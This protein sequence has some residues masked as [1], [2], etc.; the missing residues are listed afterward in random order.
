MQKKNAYSA[1][2]ARWFQD[3]EAERRRRRLRP[4]RKVHDFREPP[5]NPDDIRA[6]LDQIGHAAALALLEV[7]RS[8][9][10]RWAS[11]DQTMPRAAW[12]CLKWT[13]TGHLPGMSDA[14]ENFRIIE[15]R[16]AIVGTR[17]AYSA[18]QI[19]GFHYV[20]AALAIAHEKIERLESQ[21]IEALKMVDFGA[22]NDPYQDAVRSKAFA[23]RKA[24]RG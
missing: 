8:T 22:A 17:Y 16:L 5:P 4:G 3:M 13:A 19:I 23:H 15:D 9:L 12:L 2:L 24:G 18:G 6:A 1:A 11:G 7:H 21:L 14:W 20:E 10:A